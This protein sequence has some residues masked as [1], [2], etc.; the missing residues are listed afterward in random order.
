MRIAPSSGGASAD[1]STGR[2]ANSG[3]P[4]SRAPRSSR[5]PPCGAPKPG[6]PPPR[7]RSRRCPSPARSA[8]PRGSA[9]RASGRLHRRA[10]TPRRSS[11]R[12]SRAGAARPLPRTAPA[13]RA[14]PRSPP[15]LRL[16]ANVVQFDR[17]VLGLCLSGD[18]GNGSPDRFVDLLGRR[19]EPSFEQVAELV[20]DGLVARGRQNVDDRLRAEDLADRSGHRR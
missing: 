12:E 5:A 6:S 10:A 15:A 14:P 1:G 9:R 8:R 16:V 4:R 2:P 19:A 20:D 7:P 11:A 13:A 17:L 3:Q 18:Q